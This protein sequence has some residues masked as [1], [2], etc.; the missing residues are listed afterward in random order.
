MDPVMVDFPWT[1]LGYPAPLVHR[2]YWRRVDIQ[3]YS[4]EAIILWVIK[5]IAFRGGIS[6]SYKVNLVYLYSLW[7]R[8]TMNQYY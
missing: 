5:L 1:S 4:K 3:I 2:A 7:P 6:V 8:K